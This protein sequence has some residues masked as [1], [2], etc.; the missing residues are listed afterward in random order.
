VVKHAREVVSVVADSSKLFAFSWH[1]FHLL[2]KVWCFVDFTYP[3]RAQ[4]MPLL[5]SI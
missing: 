4:T 5:V 3:E 1:F 2:Y